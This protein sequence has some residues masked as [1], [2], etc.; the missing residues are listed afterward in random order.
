MQPKEMAL[1]IARILD[2]K[3]A[4]NILL[5]DINHLTVIADYF[6]IASGR[7]QL[8]VRS[9]SEEVEEKIAELGVQV[10]RREGQGVAR[11]VVLDFASVIVHIFH[12]Q[13]R[14]YYNLERLWM[15]GSNVIPLPN[16][17]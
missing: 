16:D 14:E 10:R 17:N 7:S 2:E 15:D 1:E 9:L 13:E 4:T 11:W 8:Q 12:E 5:L 3:K 6:V